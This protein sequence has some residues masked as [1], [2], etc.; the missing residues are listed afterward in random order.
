MVA[1]RCHAAAVR[2]P[3]PPGRPGE[4]RPGS[5]PSHD[6]GIRTGSAG[7][8]CDR[9]ALHLSGAGALLWWVI[10]R[11]RGGVLGGAPACQR[12]RYTLAV[13]SAAP[14]SPLEVES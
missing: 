11:T 10:D 2:S 1:Q 3:V 5:R 8:R 12:E 6:R 4:A 14:F 7:Q 9:V 13:E